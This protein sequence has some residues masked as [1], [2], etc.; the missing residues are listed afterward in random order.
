[1]TRLK[2]HYQGYMKQDLVLRTPYQNTHETPTIEKIVL[3]FGMKGVIKEKKRILIALLGM[4]AISG[5]KAI[6]TRSKKMVATLKI[7]KDMIIGCKA[8]LRGSN[9]FS[10][11]DKLNTIVLPR[12]KQFKGFP[13]KSVNKKGNLSFRVKNSLSFL[14]LESQYELFQ[15]LPV[16]DI[17]VVTTTDNRNKSLDLLSGLQLPFT[18]KYKDEQELSDVNLLFR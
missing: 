5:Q 3:N 16:L 6:T 2:T 8:T 13:L 17:S 14:E 12:V 11:I 9:L 18:Q 7:R 10:F 4:E 15:D 1:M